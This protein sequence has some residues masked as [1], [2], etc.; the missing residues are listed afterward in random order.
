MVIRLS[1]N[2]NDLAGGGGGLHFHDAIILVAR[3]VTHLP[4]V[5]GNMGRAKF[6][7]M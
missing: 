7:R 5:S 4:D 2:S 3:Y 6:K 1:P